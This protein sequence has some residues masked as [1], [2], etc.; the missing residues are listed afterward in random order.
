MLNFHAF[1]ATYDSVRQQHRQLEVDDYAQ[2][3]AE[4]LGNRLK[5]QG[6]L[7][8]TYDTRPSE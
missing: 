7:Q 5:H 4:S 1:R 2:R 8:A 3:V 6:M